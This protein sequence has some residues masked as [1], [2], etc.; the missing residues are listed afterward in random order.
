MGFERFVFLLYNHGMSFR[1]YLS[2]MGLGT[3]LAGMAWV[4]VLF[5]MDPFQAGAMGLIFF[6]ITLMLALTGLL[7]ILG[8][9]FRTVFKQNG[10]LL[11]DVKVSF[12]QAVVLSVVCAL[13]LRLASQKSITWYY[14]LALVVVACVL[15]CLFLVLQRRRR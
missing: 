7:S 14:V 1:W 15:E 10:V 3:A 4:I 13:A 12:R 9:G 11:E 8:L 5:T 2:L 6:Y